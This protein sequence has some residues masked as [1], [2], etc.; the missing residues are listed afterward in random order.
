MQLLIFLK[1]TEQCGTDLQD[2]TQLLVQWNEWKSTAFASQTTLRGLKLSFK[3][4]SALVHLQFGFVKDWLQAYRFT[5]LIVDLPQ[6]SVLWRKKTVSISHLRTWQGASWPSS[7]VFSWVGLCQMSW[8]WSIY[9]VELRIQAVFFD[10]WN[11]LLVEW[12]GKPDKSYFL[13]P[14]VRPDNRKR[15]HFEAPHVYETVESFHSTNSRTAMQMVLSLLRKHTE[16]ADYCSGESLSRLWKRLRR[17]CLCLDAWW[18]VHF[19]VK[20]RN[21]P[22]FTT[23]LQW[24]ISQMKR[25]AFFKRFWGY[26][27][28][29]AASVGSLWDLVW[30][31]NKCHRFTGLIVGGDKLAKRELSAAI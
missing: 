2:S 21:W 31:S 15:L 9:M 12:N 11:R 19:V 28:N 14:S 17:L 3:T 13:T 27:C 25:S 29:S 26:T 18:T 10:F 1:G 6:V 8:I 22:T 4:S 7:T 23:A 24:T 20:L 30:A 5:R 16:S